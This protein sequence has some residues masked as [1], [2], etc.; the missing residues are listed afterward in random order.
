MGCSSRR[1]VGFELA[2]R[3]NTGVLLKGDTRIKVTP[4]LKVDQ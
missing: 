2:F 3:R 1:L 4:G